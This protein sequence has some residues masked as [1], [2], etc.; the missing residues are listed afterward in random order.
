MRKL[1][2]KSAHRISMLRGLASALFSGGRIVT[3]VS[4]AKDLRPFAEKI[5]TTAKKKG[6]SPRRRVARDIKDKTVIQKLF[7]EI[8]PGYKDRP[9]G[10]T[11]I[12][13]LGTRLGDGAEVCRIELV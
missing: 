11:R 6:I 5:I 1:Q 8:A 7:K 12:I 9:G 10:Y 13:R 3:T 4:K 2:V